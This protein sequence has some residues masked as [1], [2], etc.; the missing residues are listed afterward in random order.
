[1][2]YGNEPSLNKRIRQL[3]KKFS[4]PLL[5]DNLDGKFVGSVVDTRNYLTHLDKS[6]EQSALKGKQLY[7][8]FNNLKALLVSCILKR[9]GISDAIVEKALKNKNL[10]NSNWKDINA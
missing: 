2:Q 10:V 4:P 7:F 5:R 1:M 3:S 8:A 9:I 6:K